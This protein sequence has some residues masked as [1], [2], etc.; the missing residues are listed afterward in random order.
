M[1]ACVDEESVLLAWGQS[2]R[3]TRCGLRKSFEALEAQ[4]SAS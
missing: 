1:D 3:K 2:G 4:G